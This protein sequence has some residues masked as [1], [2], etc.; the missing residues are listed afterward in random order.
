LLQGARLTA[1]ELDRAG[2][3][4][5]V[6]VDGA[7]AG[8]IARGGVDAVIVG[9]DRIVANGDVANKVGTYG[10]ALAAQAHARANAHGA[11]FLVVAPVSTID[12]RTADGAA[13]PIEE[14]A[15]DE[16]VSFAGAQAAP[17]GARAMNPAFDVTPA[18]LVTAIVT[19]RGV[20]RPVD[21]TG[22]RALVEDAAAGR[23]AA[24]NS[25]QQTAMNADDFAS[26]SVRTR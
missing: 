26:R 21:A 19:E 1:W 5:R 23:A 15:E 12:A 25:K 2:V 20:V 22:I 17:A 11:P 18:A 16:V 14:R 4:Y 24:A 9:A 7:A 6:I 10:L 3:P 13:I 8:L